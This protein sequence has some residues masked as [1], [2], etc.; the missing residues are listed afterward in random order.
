MGCLLTEIQLSFKGMKITCVTSL[1]M[2]VHNL[3][4]QCWLSFP[5]F[6][7]PLA[8]PSQHLGTP[9]YFDD[10][11]Y[12][13]N[14][15]RAQFWFQSHLSSSLECNVVKLSISWT[16]WVCDQELEPPRWRSLPPLHSW[17]SG[18]LLF[19]CS[20]NSQCKHSANFPEPKS[21]HPHFRE[22]LPHSQLIFPRKSTFLLSPQFSQAQV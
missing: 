1:N 2:N 13:I 5:F 7:L 8:L 12:I 16:L 3:G 4:N 10:C 11:P 6:L 19:F 18:A 15:M 14:K 21:H 17:S 20:T 22:V 9:T